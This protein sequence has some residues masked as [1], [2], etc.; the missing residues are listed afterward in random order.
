MSNDIASEV[1][2][3]YHRLSELMDL[4]NEEVESLDRTKKR[5]LLSIDQVRETLNAIENYVIGR[6]HV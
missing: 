2:A 3:L 6:S 4:L 1:R 5:F